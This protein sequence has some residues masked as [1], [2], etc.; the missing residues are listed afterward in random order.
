[1]EVDAEGLG[2]QLA[3]VHAGLPRAERHGEAHA[4]QDVG[5]AG[6]LAG[7]ELAHAVA[8]EVVADEASRVQALGAEQGR[9]GGLDEAVPRPA[10]DPEPQEIRRRLERRVGPGVEGDLVLLEDRGE[11]GERQPAV[12]PGQDVGGAHAELRPAGADLLDG[13]DDGPARP[14][15]GADLHLQPG[16]GVVALPVRGVVAGELE[17]VVPPE[18]EHDLIR[19]P[20][21][22]LRGRGG[23]RRK[24][25][26]T[27]GRCRQRPPDSAPA[28]SRTPAARS[29]LD[30]ISPA[31][32][33]TSLCCLRGGRRWG[34]GVAD[35]SDSRISAA[36]NFRFIM[37]FRLKSPL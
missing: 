11:D 23:G 4:R 31:L 10:P 7:Q 5:L 2:P 16:R 30:P 17:L 12:V 20:R 25:G 32:H 19:G 29:G 28:D 1:V 8:D 35:G 3:Q 34:A 14:D 9:E 18:L 22:R 26:R 24:A 33:P 37:F 6:Q 15:A 27:G 13:G 36:F 21:R